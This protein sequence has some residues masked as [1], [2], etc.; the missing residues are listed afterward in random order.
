MKYSL[1]EGARKWM[2]S[3]KQYR[4]VLLVLFVG[5]ALMLLPTGEREVR[6]ESP[7]QETEA[8]EWFELEE[9][10]Q[11]LART[12]SQVEGAGETTVMLTLKSGSRQIL[13]QNLERDGDRTVSTAVTVGGSGSAQEVVPLQT[14]GPQFQGALVICPGGEE[15]QVRLRLVAAVTALTGLGSN[16]ISICKST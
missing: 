8:A 15:P 10:E 9:F 11:R 7:T 13:A 1:P 12:L 3:L 6:Q 2:D 14:V 16:H 4:T 5:M